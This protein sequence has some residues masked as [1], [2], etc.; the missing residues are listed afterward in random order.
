MDILNTL[1]LDYPANRI[2]L[3]P[4]FEMEG[5]PLLLIET[6]NN[7]IETQDIIIECSVNS[8]AS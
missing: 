6:P 3:H 7:K 1:K 4:R 5:F 8:A 2:Y